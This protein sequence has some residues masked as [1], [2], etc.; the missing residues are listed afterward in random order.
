L[1]FRSGVVAVPRLS[2]KLRVV[3][4]PSA[5][6]V[7]Y[8]LELSKRARSIDALYRK[9]DVDSS[10]T[11]ST[12]IDF[13]Q[14]KFLK[15]GLTDAEKQQAKDAYIAY[16]HAIGR[17]IDI[18]GVVVEAKSVASSVYE[19]FCS[20]LSS[21]AVMEAMPSLFPDG[22]TSLCRELE[23]LA[24]RLQ[25]FDTGGLPVDDSRTNDIWGSFLHTKFPFDVPLPTGSDVVV[26]TKAQSK[27]TK[28]QPKDTLFDQ[29]QKLLRSTP[30]SA[31]TGSKSK[32]VVSPGNDVSYDDLLW[33]RTCLEE[34]CV[35]KS[36][37]GQGV[38]FTV[39]QLVGEIIGFL[40]GSA[41]E[42]GLL[43]LLGF[44]DIEL[45]GSIVSRR[46]KICDQWDRAVSV[47]EQVTVN[48]SKDGNRAAKMK[49][50]KKGKKNQSSGQ[51]IDPALV[52]GM[53]DGPV[54][55]ETAPRAASSVKA[56][57]KSG[58]TS[59][60][61]GDGI[62]PKACLPS[63]TK[64][65]WC[66]NNSYEKVVVPH[67][68][69]VKPDSS[70]LIP[71]SDLPDWARF[72]FRDTKQLN[73]LQSSVFNAAF[74]RSDNVL[75]G[76]PTGAGKTNVAL[77]TILRLIG[78]H[79]GPTGALSGEFKCVYM[80]PMKALASEVVEKF[81]SRLGSLG[82]E[83][84][85]LTG[86]MQLTKKE[87]DRVHV[88]V[89]VPE[90]WDVM[91]R[92]SS[93]GGG[94]GSDQGIMRMVQLVII[95]EVHLLNETRGAVIETVVAR[96]KRYMDTSG[97][98]VRLVAL[99]ATM[100]NYQ[101]IAAFLRVEEHNLFFF[102]GRYRPVPLEQSF[103]GVK[104]TDPMKRVQ[105]YNDLAYERCLEA[106]RDGHQAMVFVHSRSDTYATAEAISEIAN[107]KG[108]SSFFDCE[109]NCKN[110]H[111]WQQ[112][113]EKS[114]NRKVRELFKHGFGC[115]HAGMLRSD[116]NLTE[117]MF[118]EGAIKILVCT[119]T[120]AWGVNLPA[121]YVIIKGTSVYNA[122]AGGFTDLGILDVLQIFGRAG[123]PQFDT[124][125][126]ATLITAHSSLDKYLR[127]L[128]NQIPVDSQF[129]VQ[130]CNALN[131]EIASGTVLDE[132]DAIEWLQY[133]YAHYIRLQRFDK[134][135]VE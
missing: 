106:V 121:R 69:R 134:F 56:T 7:D 67:V 126:N 71:I 84:R 91:T 55:K 130:L 62:G 95:D 15:P 94:A 31:S 53:I 25:A 43:D 41:N 47:A 87:I 70:K 110:Y 107:K 23:R 5:A 102:D 22:S 66:D 131:A 35:R 82:V 117:K 2:G 73:A 79:L 129:E 58:F 34:Y 59:L 122:D 127:L 116:R 72:C 115:H 68:N 113:V 9:F 108:D 52:L 36:E 118:H 44:E 29:A 80:A 101:D 14:S 135:M 32:N 30:A 86:D 49:S 39:E 77:L 51:P 21:R 81:Q 92:N 125:G 24:S 88:L 100:P 65:T 111:S 28:V 20:G 97:H 83:V 54:T 33:L 50:Q 46:M 103:L 38:P 89:T 112:H 37:S 99:S 48:V 128:T 124:I 12:V 133:S 19:S 6:V 96:T 132:K 61:L 78:Q 57:N 60:H 75:V 63:G 4:D 109:K 93:T 74:N 17:A 42:N 120:L 76:A 18:G 16:L 98:H 27:P 26:P 64:R 10:K 119:A 8:E 13:K 123:R 1:I 105:K 45:V 104:A 114:R 3:L 40:R 90:K 85:E 11:Q